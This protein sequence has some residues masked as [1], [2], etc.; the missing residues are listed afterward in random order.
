VPLK[1]DEAEARKTGKMVGSQGA[2]WLSGRMEFMVLEKE[3]GVTFQYTA[4]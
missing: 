4:Q 3:E 1:I 2:G